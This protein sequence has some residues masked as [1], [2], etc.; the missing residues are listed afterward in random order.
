MAE[1]RIETALTMMEMMKQQKE[2]KKARREDLKRQEER[3]AVL[4]E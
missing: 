1:E 3:F 4:L 2:R